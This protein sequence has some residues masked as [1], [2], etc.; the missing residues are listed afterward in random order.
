M[1]QYGNYDIEPS[2]ILPAVLDLRPLFRELFIAESNLLSVQVVARISLQGLIT[3][4]AY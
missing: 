3:Q 1:E 4:V 2:L